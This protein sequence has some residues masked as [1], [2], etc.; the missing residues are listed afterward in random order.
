MTSVHKPL[1]FHKNI[2][3]C[4]SLHRF[5]WLRQWLQVQ[6]KE[7][8]A[9]VEI[10][11]LDSTPGQTHYREHVST[12]RTTK[13]TFCFQSGVNILGMCTSLQSQ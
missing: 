2:E 3:Y 13:T 10:T 1:N 5:P 4:T 11:T 8:E 9:A 6:G 7:S 12:P